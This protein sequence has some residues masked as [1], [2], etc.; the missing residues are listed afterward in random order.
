[1][2]FQSRLSQWVNR[3]RWVVLKGF[4]SEWI[5]SEGYLRWGSLRVGSFGVGYLRVGHRRVASLRAVSLR[6][7]YFS[8]WVVPETAVSLE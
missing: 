7:S 1:M 4:F 5:V 3:L 6:V 2:L 8:E